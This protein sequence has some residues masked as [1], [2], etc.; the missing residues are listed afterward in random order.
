MIFKLYNKVGDVRQL[1]F[2]LKIIVYVAM[3]YIIKNL[4]FNRSVWDFTKFY[5]KL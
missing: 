4:L 1:R 2:I 3:A 5:L